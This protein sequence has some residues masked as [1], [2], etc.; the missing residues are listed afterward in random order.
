MAI[1]SKIK[2]KRW[3]KILASPHFNS[4]QIGETLA[5]EPQS[6]M[7]RPVSVSM[8]H[9]TG[10]MKRQN[11]TIAFEVTNVRDEN[12]ITEI[13]KY[14]LNPASIKRFVR[15]GKDRLDMS[16]VCETEDGKSVII[17]PFLLTLKKTGGAHQT[18]LRKAAIAAIKERVSKTKYA[19]LFR[20][21]ITNRLQREVR[22]KLSKIYPLKTCEIR[23]LELKKK[24]EF[25]T[26]ETQE[27]PKVSGPKKPEGLL[28]EPIVVAE[29]PKEE[30]KEV[31]KEEVKEEPKKKE[32]AEKVISKE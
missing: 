32:E 9:L 11:I 26:K 1:K 28:K 21:V 5:E 25:I 27:T 6:L 15:K 17:K 22:S 4:R 20:E 16:F 7:G 30:I 3:F 29:A 23:V 24:K 18:S 10:E 31:P 19:D 12:A 2:K 14:K 8:M 13:R